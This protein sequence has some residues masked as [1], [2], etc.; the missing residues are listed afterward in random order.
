MTATHQ[1][2]PAPRS[3]TRRRVL[4][5]IPAV[6]LAVVLIAAAL[7]HEVW[8]ENSMPVRGQAVA[9][10]DDGVLGVVDRTRVFFGH[11][12]IGENI[13]DAVPGIYAAHDRVAP[14][15]EEKSTRPGPDGG[16]ISHAY[17]G[18]NEKPLAKIADFDSALRSG[19][20]DEVDVAMMKFCYLDITTSTDV[21]ALFNRYRETLAALS[22]TYPGI[23]F[24]HVTVPLTTDSGIKN[25]VKILLGGS[26]RYG[27]GENVARERYNELLRREYADQQIL[28]LAAIE[29]TDPQGNRE[30]LQYRGQPYFAL[31]QGYAADLGHLNTAGSEVAATAFLRAIASA[32]GR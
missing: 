11:Q 8:R 18:E 26:D 4:Q 27:Q 16:F 23:T 13:L 31:H 10:V 12:S 2:K 25:R 1:T 17:L 32:R 19:L 5:A 7:T 3:T 6:V 21:E 28:D 20:G 24:V 9:A 22:T 29:S 30:Q 14:P 15:I